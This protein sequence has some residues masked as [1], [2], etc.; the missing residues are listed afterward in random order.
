MSKTKNVMG[1][2]RRP[3]GDGYTMLRLGSMILADLD[4]APLLSPGSP[5]PA[6]TANNVVCT[7]WARCRHRIFVRS[8]RHRT[9][10]ARCVRSPD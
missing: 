3:Q 2:S 9:V 6:T 7:R 5:I 10:H 4:V 8:A 1:N